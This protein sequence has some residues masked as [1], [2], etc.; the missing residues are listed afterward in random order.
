MVMHLWV[1]VYQKCRYLH[2]YVTA[3]FRWPLFFLSFDLSIVSDI[4][5]LNLQAVECNIFVYSYSVFIRMVL[6]MRVL[7]GFIFVK[8]LN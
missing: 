7:T 3:S 4:K 6:K 8:F 5:I 2:V 1:A